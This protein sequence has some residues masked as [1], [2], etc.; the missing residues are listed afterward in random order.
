M[1]LPDTANSA[2]WGT[3]YNVGY[4][5]FTYYDASLVSTGIAYFTRWSRMSDIKISHALVVTGPDECVEAL[6]SDN[7]V[8]SSPL[9]KY[10]NEEKCAL[11]LRKPNGW[12]QT[13]GD[14]IAAA[15]KSQVGCK[16]DFNLIASAAAHGTFVGTLI[17]KI[18]KGV[19]DRILCKL[20][21]HDRKW[22]CSELAAYCL[23]T[24]SP[25]MNKGILREDSETITPQEL[26]EDNIV[27][28][29]WN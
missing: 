2:A 5:G 13:M 14:E 27:F 21:N 29:P 10:L 18:F 28:E 23:K 15:A 7:I 16:Y 17:N 6:A 9:S 24:Q 12:T 26:F 19:P 11:Y 1:Y 4:I 8:T 3:N 22:I 25:L 20:L